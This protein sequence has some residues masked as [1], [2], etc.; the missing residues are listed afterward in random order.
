[1]VEKLKETVKQAQTRQWVAIISVVS[2]F[3]LLILLCF[4]P[5]PESNVQLVSNAVSLVIGASIAT[6][7]GFYFGDSQGDD[8]SGSSQGSE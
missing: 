8:D 1:M 6:I 2:V 7:Y 3:F 4:K 5:I